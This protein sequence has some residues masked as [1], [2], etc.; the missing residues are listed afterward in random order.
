[1]A[2]FAYRKNLDGS[3]QAPTLLYLIAKQGIAIAIGDAVRVNTSGFVDVCD[4]GEGIAGFCVAVVTR[5]GTAKA[6]DAGSNDTWTTS[7]DNQTVAMDMVAFIPALPNYLFY[8]DADASL[9]EAYIGMYYD[10]VSH[11][12]VQG[13]SRH[14]TTQKTV[15]LWEYDPN[16][17]SDASEGLFQVV[18]SQFGQDSWDRTT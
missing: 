15:R 11:T 13:S 5:K 6:V 3:N 14:D 12:Q 8:N 1:M 4:A 18:E 16:H 10:L 2:G 9:A 17:E 7:A